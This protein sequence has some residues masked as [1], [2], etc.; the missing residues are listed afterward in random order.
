VVFA[1]DKP[2]R[3][4][5]VVDRATERRLSS[6]GCR[7]GCG[8]ATEAFSSEDD[9]QASHSCGVALGRSFGTDESV[10]SVWLESCGGRAET[11][12]GN[13]GRRS[14]GG[15][16]R[17]KTMKRRRLPRARE[18]C[19]TRSG[20]RTL[21]TIQTERRGFFG[22]AAHARWKHRADRT[23]VDADAPT[24]RREIGGGQSTR[25]RSRRKRNGRETPRKR[26]VTTLFFESCR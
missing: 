16:Q 19:N 8:C 26:S 25:K 12:R 1:T 10:R 17:R 22:N 4:A 23:R 15:S 3:N 5:R 11:V 21:R 2:A 6:E 9:S 14:A 20:E 18:S 24:G 13:P 7:P